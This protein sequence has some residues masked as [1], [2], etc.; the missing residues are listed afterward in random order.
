M[1]YFFPFPVT[2]CLS[3]LCSYLINVCLKDVNFS[4]NTKEDLFLLIVTV[5]K[6]EHLKALNKSIF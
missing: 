4:A 2:L 1:L 3:I 6:K 5:E